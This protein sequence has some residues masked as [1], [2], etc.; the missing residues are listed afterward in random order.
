MS[1]EPQ[2]EAA[3]LGLPV[4]A[5]HTTT[6]RVKGLWPYLGPAFVASVAYIDPG[7]FATNIAG[8]SEFGFKLLWVILAANL[9]A[10]VIQSLSAKL[11]IATGKGL[12][13]VCRE[14]FPRPVGLFLWI[15]A[16]IVAMSTDLAEVLGGAIGF[17][18]LFG[19]DLLPA[20][21]LTGVVAFAILYL[22]KYGHR[23][24]EYVIMFFI[25]VVGFCYLA[26]IFL[27]HPPAG[28]I[29]HGMFVPFAK[30]RALYLAIGILGAT[31]M[32]HVV[33]L[34]SDL[35]KAR[36]TP[37]SAAH[38]KR[39]YRFELI[40]IAIAMNGAWFVN[41]AM[42]IMAASVFFLHGIHVESVEAAH[43]TL[44]PLAGALSSFL[45]GISLLA[46]GLSSS[47]VGTMAGQGIMEGFIGY[48]IP[49]FLRRGLT[50]IPAI[51]VIAI[52]ADPLRILILSQVVLSF[53][54]PFAVVPLVLF[55]SKK[56]L[57]G[58]L[59]NRRS[60]TLIATVIA[61]MILSLNGVL[62]VQTLT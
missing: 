12:A 38:A 2:E 59:T 57:M 1:D 51:I 62:L 7:N 48:K 26:E 29:L 3:A 37:Q 15:I 17:K 8:G 16:E 56:R 35:T 5:G 18:L 46:S 32:P 4:K 6:N 40:D 42:L 50:L 14:E 41:S 21:I 61:L 31:V 36:I 39:L 34:H 10:I 53:G 13:R 54:L 9:M 60:T 27:V 30:G 11:G 55:T 20:A 47:T 58:Q 23:P 28:P 33:F 25:G 22:H 49:L 24:V 43:K 19:I 44:T 45:F 52:G